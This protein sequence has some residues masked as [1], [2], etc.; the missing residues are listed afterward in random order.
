MGCEA[1]E[2]EKAEHTEYL[3]KKVVLSQVI[4]GRPLV[5]H[6]DNGSLMKAATF[7]DT[8]E[9]LGVQNSFSGSRLS[10]DNPHFESLFK[11]IKYHPMYPHKGLAD[12]SEARK[13]AKVNKSNATTY[14]T[15]TGI[16]LA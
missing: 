5:L 9:I 7:S 3:V 10:N 16:V 6:S 14:L 11:T 4:Q 1:W 13:R 15:T 8:L 12:L 2:S